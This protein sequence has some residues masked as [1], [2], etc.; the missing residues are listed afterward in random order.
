[1]QIILEVS[2]LLSHGHKSRALWKDFNRQY[3]LNALSNFQLLCK[4]MQLFKT[5]T[6]HSGTIKDCVDS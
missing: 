2:T 5:I 1:M 3:T 4:I 6:L